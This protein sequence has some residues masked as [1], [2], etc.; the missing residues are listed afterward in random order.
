MKPA[1]LPSWA[2]DE[3]RPGWELRRGDTNGFVAA[4]ARYGGRR[5][6]GRFGGRGNR[7]TAG[8]HESE[9]EGEGEKCPQLLG[10]AGEGYG[11]VRGHARI[12]FNEGQVRGH[13]SAVRE[14][15]DTRQNE[16]RRCRTVD[17]GRL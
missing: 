4:D 17:A 12:V 5:G 2:R 8:G 15:R 13:R 16:R 7:A 3:N 11:D 6:T 10:C 1:R 14:L 9:G